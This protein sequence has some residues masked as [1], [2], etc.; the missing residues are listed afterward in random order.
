ML[1]EPIRCINYTKIWLSMRR[2]LESGITYAFMFMLMGG[3]TALLLGSELRERTVVEGYPAASIALTSLEGL[4]YAGCGFLV[5]LHWKSTLRGAAAAWPYLLVALFAIVSTFW[6]VD[7][8]K[9]FLRGGVVMGTT[10]FGVYLGS[11]YTTQEIQT[12]LMRSFLGLVGLSLVVLI[13]APSLVLDSSHTGT[14][15]GLTEHKNLLGEFMG[16]FLLLACTYHFRSRFRFAKIATILLALVM[17]ASA[18]SGSAL[19]STAAG[20]AVL[21]VLLLMRFRKNQVMPLAA[22]GL[23]LFCGLMWFAWTEFDSLLNLLGKD[24]TLTGR[25]EIWGMVEEMIARR[26]WLGYG[27]DAF[28]QGLHGPSFAIVAQEGWEVP[29]SHNGY[30]EALLGLG[31]VGMGII[32]FALLRTVKDALLCVREN[33]RIEGLWPFVYLT[34]YLVHSSA[35]ASLFRR[36]GYTYLLT[37]VLATSLALNRSRLTVGR[38]QNSSPGITPILALH[39]ADRCD[40]KNC[41]GNL[42]FSS[43]P[44][45]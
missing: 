39:I 43:T 15:R 35:E 14:F 36:D 33:F 18:R 20:L 9:T 4:I 23:V 34:F 3:F 13:V 6:S 19:I 41:G 38:R 21:P 24:R 44:E 10:I 22:I 26:P 30:L 12:I 42:G 5:L 40:T 31:V 29:H 7:P 32:G 1:Y 37:V 2:I 17:L 16:Q 25:A 27:Y 28:W 11:R 8:A 45:A